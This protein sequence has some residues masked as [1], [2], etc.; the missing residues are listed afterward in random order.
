VTAPIRSAVGYHLFKL[1]DREELSP[2]MLAEAR[3]QARDLLQQRKGQE[4]LDEWV[5]TLRRRALISTRL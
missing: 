4:R 1:E 2:A 5:E 3:Q